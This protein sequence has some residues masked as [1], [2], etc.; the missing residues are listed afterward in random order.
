ML[1]CVAFVGVLAVEVGLFYVGR[2][3]AGPALGGGLS[4]AGIIVLL[5]VG[6]VLAARDDTKR[7]QGPSS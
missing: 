5:V 2:S 3:A 7:R 1:S 6:F 4:V